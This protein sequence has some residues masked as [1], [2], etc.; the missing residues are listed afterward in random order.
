M[1]GAELTVKDINGVVVDKWTSGKN[2]HIIEGLTVGGIYVMEETV[3]ADGY[4]K[5][6]NIQLEISNT[7]EVQHV[8]MIDKI[9]DMSKVDMGGKE[10][11]GAEMTVT[12]EDG[13]VVDEWTSTA[14]PHKIKGLEEGKS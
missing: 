2:T 12:D 3:A 14:E 6:S 10:V 7:G 1:E 11:E 9:V 5:A 8:D 4:V 13:N